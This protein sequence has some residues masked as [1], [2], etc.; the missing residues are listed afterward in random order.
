METGGD[1]QRLEETARDW[2]R[3]LETRGDCQRLGETR[4]DWR[5]DNVTHTYIHTYIHTY[6]MLVLNITTIIIYCSPATLVTRLLQEETARD[7]KRLPE[8][9]GRL[10]ETGGDW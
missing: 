7:C 3:L 1:C 4:G 5:C 2:E 9:G 8:T 10:M 6:N